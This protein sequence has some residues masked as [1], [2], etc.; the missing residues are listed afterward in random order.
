MRTVLS[1]WGWFALGVLLIIW[2]PTVAIVRLVTSPF[3]KGRYWA[4]Y[5]F[6]K[7]AVVHGWL[8][9]MWRFRTSGTMITDPRH[10]YVVVSNH[11]SFVD[12]FLLSHLKWEMKYL[13][14]K[15]FF[16]YPLAGWMLRLAGDIRLVRGNKDSIVNAMEQCKDR[17]AK[18][19]CVMIFP[20][21][22]RTRSGELGAFKDGAFRL[23]IETQTPV[24][25]VVVH[26]TYRAL[27]SGDW[28][29]GVCDSEARVLEPI[30][31]TGMTLDDVDSLRDRVRTL[32]ADELAVMTAAAGDGPVT[33]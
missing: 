19:T 16:Q 2:T 20:E 5:T 9:P 32:I 8:N 29:F 7:I 23:A 3:D 11:E 25:P 28:R 24:L 17:L 14:K 15:D 30:D 13:A 21:G 12:M 18:K 1:V 27:T 33:S 22:T 10:P 6:R 31:T 26:G 4:G